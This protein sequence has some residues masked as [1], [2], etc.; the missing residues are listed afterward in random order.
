MNDTLKNLLYPALLFLPLNLQARIE[1]H[2]AYGIPP[3][4]FVENVDGG[5]SKWSG[6]GRIRTQTQ[7]LC[8]ATL[9]DTRTPDTRADAPAYIVTSSR[10]LHTDNREIQK[11]RPIVG[12]V[13]FNSFADSI[14]QLKLYRLKTLAWSSSLGMDLAIIELEK[15][16]AA[17]LAE[18]IEPVKLAAAKPR[19]K[20]D[21]LALGVPEWATLR[22]SACTHL[23]SVEILEQPWVWR[24]TMKNRCRGITTG[25]FGGPLLDRQTGELLGIIATTTH[26]TR[27]EKQCLAGSP[28]EI[29]WGHPD[30]QP[31]TNYGSSLAF[32]NKCFVAGRLTTDPQRCD[33]YPTTSIRFANPQPLQ[34]YFVTRPNGNT[35]LIP[36]WKAPFSLSTPFYR[37]K[38]VRRATDCEDPAG[39]GPVTP[40][41]NATI[42]L[43]IGPQTGLQMLCILGMETQ[44]Q[45]HT[46]A[47]MKG[48]L[49]LAVELAEPG[50]ARSP[51]MS[52]EL[53]RTLLGAY[54]VT[55]QHYPPFYARYEY[56]YGPAHSTDCRNNTGFVEIPPPQEEE[57]EEDILP[58]V[59]PNLPPIVKT[60]TKTINVRIDELPNGQYKE[61]FSVYREPIKLCTR[62][63][64]QANQVSPVRTDI[65][66]PR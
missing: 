18:G 66:R 35:D 55:W 8:T 29:T 6:I 12:T 51:D 20:S 15:P 62:S 64:D 28:C 33:L 23:A 54:A 59:A 36:N 32:L 46:P 47:R 41:N 45:Q 56:K 58:T 19:P 42:D 44:T 17:L 27:E 38:T 26:G 49:T 2:S 31:A 34:Q 1:P 63:Y 13:A 40:G 57:D 5:F 24:S 30:W 21:I 10:C 39:Y 9:L 22:V 60:L 7:A 50:P 16:L 37:F 14:E 53:D 52:I 61:L 11:D 3:P 48:A 25:S 65:L 4:A 43:P